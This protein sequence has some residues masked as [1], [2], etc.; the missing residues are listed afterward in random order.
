MKNRQ[1]NVIFIRHGET[2][3][4]KEN[5]YFGHLDPELNETG[6]YQLKKTRKLLK[7]FEKNINIVYSSDLKRCMESM[8]ILK[9]GAKIKKIPLNEFREM[10]F[11]IFEGKTYEEI[12]AEFPEEVEKMNKDWREYKVPQ[13]ESLKEVMERAVEK[14]EELTKKHK[15]KT[16]VIVS[17]AGVIKSIVSYYLYGNLDGYW[18][19]KVDNGSMTKMCILE[20]GFTY[21]DYINRL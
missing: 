9:I 13:G 17:H 19:I 20:D 21:F 2:D 11:G 18:K 16:I 4:N 8:D 6:I 14:L 15:N 12:S 10:N 3:M 5:L 7:Y 1:T